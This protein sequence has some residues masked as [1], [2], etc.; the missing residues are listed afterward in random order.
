M[1]V[2]YLIF[3]KRNV[4]IFNILFYIILIV[5]IVC[6]AVVIS[7]YHDIKVAKHKNIELDS[8]KEELELE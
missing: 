1:V 4:I 3:N 7:C 6:V 5:A 2:D 8:L